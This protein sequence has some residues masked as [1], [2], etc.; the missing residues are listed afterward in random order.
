VATKKMPFK[1]IIWAFRFK[2]IL[3][4]PGHCGGIARRDYGTGLALFLVRAAWATAAVCGFY[5][6]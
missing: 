4:R 2:N 6:F 3:G 1:K 5:Y